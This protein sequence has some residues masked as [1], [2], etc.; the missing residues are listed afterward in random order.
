MRYLKTYKIFENSQEEILHIHYGVNVM[1]ECDSI[2][3]DIKD[4]LLELDDIG[5]FVSIGYAPM[6][7]TYVDKN[8]K[9]VVSVQ[10]KPE[11]CDENE[12]EIN[13]IFDRIKDYVKPKGFSTGFG[14]WDRGSSFEPMKIYQMNIQ[15]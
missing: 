6:T 12:Q 11:L 9:L 13:S 5:L 2:L 7:L 14:S 8:P 4:M 3:S 10:G 1:E 15:K